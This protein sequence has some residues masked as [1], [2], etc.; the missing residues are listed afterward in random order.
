MSEPTTTDRTAPL[1]IWRIASALIT[2]LFNL[3]GAPERLAA[4]HTITAKSRALILSWLRCAE[5]L[6][7]QLLVVEASAYERDA[8][9]SRPTRAKPRLRKPVSFEADAPETWRVSF[10]CILDRRRPRR[11]GT[12]RHPTTLEACAGGPRKPLSSAWP[13]AERFEALLRVHNN[14]T[15]FAKR[16][17]RRLYA[18]PRLV[19]GV[20]NKPIELMHRISEDD[21]RLIRDLAHARAIVFESG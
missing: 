18:A 19:I 20:L 9:T 8:R 6:V 2:T 14:P 11:R 1:H 12:R 3:F 10:R 17:A 4:K 15:P 16:L 5:A 13:L 7:R 21:F